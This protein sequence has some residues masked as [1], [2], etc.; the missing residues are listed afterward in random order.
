MSGSL[1]NVQEEMSHN[2]NVYIAIFMFKVLMYL[3]GSCTGS[4]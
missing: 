2:G 3:A 4:L 1:I